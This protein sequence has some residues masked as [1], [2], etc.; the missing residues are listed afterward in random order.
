M[1]QNSFYRQLLRKT[2]DVN[3]ISN[4]ILHNQVIG[5]D[6]NLVPVLWIDFANHKAIP[7]NNFERN[8]NISCPT[9][10]PVKNNLNLL[11]VVAYA[12]NVL[13]VKHI[14]VCGDLKEN[15]VEVNHEKQNEIPSGRIRQFTNSSASR[16]LLLDVINNNNERFNTFAAFKIVDCVYQL[17]ETNII[18]TAWANKTDVSIYAVGHLPN[19]QLMDFGVVLSTSDSLEISHKV[20][21]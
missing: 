17:A 12:V 7:A 2:V 20:A 15:G 9:N 1:S 4:S 11:N 21:I 3:G 13:K 10:L 5:A 18:Q 16:N 8:N 14:I 6:G 19:A